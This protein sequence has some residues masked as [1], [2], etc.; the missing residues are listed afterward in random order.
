[1]SSVRCPGL[2][3]NSKP[4]HTHNYFVW[5]CSVDGTV[6]KQPNA[7]VRAL[8]RAVNPDLFGGAPAHEAQVRCALYVFAMMG[9]PSLCSAGTEGWICLCAS[10]WHTFA[11]L[12][13]RPCC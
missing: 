9:L 6:M 10:H 2:V 4:P 11:G 13:S 5:S 3:A 1:V 12:A 7:V 8:A